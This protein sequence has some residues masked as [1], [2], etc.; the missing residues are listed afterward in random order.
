MFDKRSLD[1]LASTSFMV[2][3]GLQVALVRS[4]DQRAELIGVMRFGA[5][6]T[7]PPNSSLTGSKPDTLLFYEIAPVRATGC[8]PS[9]RCSSRR[10]LPVS[11]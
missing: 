8:T 3:P 5:G 7:I 11:Y 4:R 2:V 1:S 6:A 10:A 9:S